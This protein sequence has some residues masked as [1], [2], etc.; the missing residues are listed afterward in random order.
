MFIGCWLL[1]LF[2]PAGECKIWI[3][4]VFLHQAGDELRFIISLYRLNLGHFDQD[5][6]DK[7]LVITTDLLQLFYAFGVYLFV[8]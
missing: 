2:Y 6:F 8:Y 4:K 5:H 7:G 1:T 3:A